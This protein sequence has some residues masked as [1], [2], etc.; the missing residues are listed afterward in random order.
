MT[1]ILSGPGKSAPVA[2]TPEH[3]AICH[4]LD[5]AAV[6]ER[7]IAPFGFDP[8]EREALILLTA[9]HD[10]GKI[11]AGFRQMLRNFTEPAICRGSEIEVL[12]EVG[13]AGQTP[14]SPRR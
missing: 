11:N 10:L 2:D 5:M 14:I 6:I 1:D 13:R 4:M 3:P 8:S 9:L 7:L 12:P